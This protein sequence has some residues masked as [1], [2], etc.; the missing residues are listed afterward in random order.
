MENPTNTI[1]DRAIKC[2]KDGLSIEEALLKW[3][4]EEKNLK[5]LLE[6]AELIMNLPK[7]EAPEPAMQRKYALSPSKTSWYS[8]MHLS[9]LTGI[10][11]AVFFLLI[12]LGGTGYATLK[13][14]PGQKLFAIKKSGEKIRLILAQSP[15]AKAN[16]RIAITRQR[17]NEAE[18]IFKG[19][20][21]NPKIENAILAELIKETKKSLEAVNQVAKKNRLNG[22]AYPI[23]S[24]LED[25][26]NKQVA[27]IKEVKPESKIAK[28]T[29][30]N[31]NKL[32]KI[33]ELI[34]AAT[35]ERS[36]TEL[37]PGTNTVVISG[38]ISSITKTKITVE[39]TVFELTEKTQIKDYQG[40][41]IPSENLLE[42]N[43]V[44]IL[45]TKIQGKLIAQRIIVFAKEKK[46]AVGEVKGIETG[47]T[48]TSTTPETLIIPETET[49]K[50]PKD[51]KPED[52]KPNDI[53]GTFI[54]EDPKP[55]TAF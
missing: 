19:D 53:Q 44:N 42:K 52:I 28:A 35:Q 3:P 29:E 5:P 25:L 37:G 17:L 12:I 46:E 43:K 31:S 20:H 21:N 34:V 50:I 40:N 55:Q 45:G 38:E 4:E 1:L 27:L 36:L 14:L 49:S 10:I 51:I 32:S 18:K 39:K 15:E 48:E 33:K 24:S 23:I 7:T 8:W 16:L 41:I 6:S 13:S 22:K 26:T 11:V 30:E 47:N 2:I 54:I 9:R